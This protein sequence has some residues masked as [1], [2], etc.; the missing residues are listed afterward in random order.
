L[1]LKLGIYGMNCRLS[2]RWAYY[3]KVAAVAVLPCTPLFLA[4]S[5]MAQTLANP[6]MA[7]V[8]GTTSEE[9]GTFTASTTSPYAPTEQINGW[10]SPGGYSFV[11][12]SN[13]TTVAANDSYGNSNA[14]LDPAVTALTP[15]ANFMGTDINT[16]N[17]IITDT[18]T[19]L[20][21]GKKVAVSFAWAGAEQ[22]GFTCATPTTCSV[23]WTVSLNASGVSGGGQTTALTTFPSQGFTGWIQTTFDFIPTS[24]TEVLTF[25]G[26]GTPGAGDPPFALLA[27]VTV[28]NVPEPGSISI[29]IAGIAGLSAVAR[30]RRARGTPK[31]AA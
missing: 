27:N 23:D 16:G 13:F 28:T 22:T 19:G 9:F 6:S 7:L 2:R 15:G 26:A 11:F 1:P 4:G 25:L 24:T 18:V 20:T 14:S 31:A 10:A 17:A 3:T 29:V 30:R 5:A 12:T 8:S 21:I